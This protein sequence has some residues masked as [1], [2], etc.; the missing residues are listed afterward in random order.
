MNIHSGTEKLS[1]TKRRILEAAL[2]LFAEQGFHGTA[3]PPVAERAQ[4]GAGTIYRHFKNKDDLVNGVF[5][6]A[7]GLLKQHLMQDWDFTASPREQFGLMWQ[8]LWSF[9]EQHPKAFLFLE[10]QHH[11]PYLTQES[12]NVELEVLAPIFMFCANARRQGLAKD[13]PAEAVIAMIWGSFVGLVKAQHFGY[14]ELT[15]DL[16]KQSEQAS[17]DLF[18]AHTHS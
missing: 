9:A 17:W 12:R 3:V 5:Q 13:M 1:A 10:L 11:T 2:E 4:V 14:F 8:R 7:K 18:T 16:R 6:Y 15:D